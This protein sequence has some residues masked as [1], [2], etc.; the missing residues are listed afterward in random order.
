MYTIVQ[1]KLISESSI[2]P[3]LETILKEATPTAHKQRSEITKTT[4]D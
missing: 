2:I 3:S 4:K 1:E